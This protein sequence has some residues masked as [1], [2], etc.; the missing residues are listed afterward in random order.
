MT[1][2]TMP[3]ASILFLVPLAMANT[4]DLQTI[5]SGY[6]LIGAAEHV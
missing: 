3:M 5:D 2:A 1:A 6:D 4:S